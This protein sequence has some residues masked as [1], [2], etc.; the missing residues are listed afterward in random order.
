ML[1]EALPKVFWPS[2]ERDAGWQRG[3]YPNAR[4]LTESTLNLETGGNTVCPAAHASNAEPAKFATLSKA[5]S[6]IFD[7]Q[8]CH[9]LAVHEP[10]RECLRIRVAHGVGNGFLPDTVEGIGDSQGH[11]PKIAISCRDHL[12]RTTF[13]HVSGASLKSEQ[14]ILGL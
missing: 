14:Q 9:V 1:P 4:A 10:D 13:Y 12:N 2:G 8:A 11:W 6:I 3:S 5:G 7:Q